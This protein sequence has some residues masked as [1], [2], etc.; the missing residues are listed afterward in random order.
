MGLPGGKVIFGALMA[1]SLAQTGCLPGIT[2]PVMTTDRPVPVPTKTPTEGFV[3]RVEFAQL[4]VEGTQYGTADMSGDAVIMADSPEINGSVIDEGEIEG[5]EG[6][7]IPGFR[8]LSTGARKPLQNAA[9]TLRGYD[10]K[11]TPLIGT[12][13][14]GKDG[15]FKF[16]SVPAHVAF[17]LD[18]TYSMGGQ[19]YRMFGLV[20]TKSLSEVTTVEIDVP[21]TLVARFLLRLMQR[22]QT[23]NVVNKPI[24]FRDLSHKDYDP[25][26]KDLRDVL[27]GGLPL[28][29]DLTKVNQPDG[30]WTKEK[31][32]ADS[33]VVFLD[34]LAKSSDPAYKQIRF[35]M[36]RL[37][38]EIARVNQIP[39]ERL[40]PE[41]I[42]DK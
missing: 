38:R 15:K 8:V 37:V 16:R 21:S 13:V 30:N 34:T 3:P 9:V 31:D 23:P 20:R 7:D 32:A 35:D 14:S 25:L 1:A 28:N 10:F 18:S 6:L 42:I 11:V 29:L 33:A 19:T 4:V 41:S 27:A 39:Y 24:D 26:L 17:F 40:A 2:T 12:K 22:A 5:L 36:Q